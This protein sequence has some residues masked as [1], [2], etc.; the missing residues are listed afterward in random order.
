M[1]TVWLLMASS[2]PAQMPLTRDLVSLDPVSIQTHLT[3]DFLHTSPISPC[4]EC[5]GPSPS[6]H[7]SQ[8]LR[9]HNQSWRGRNNVNGQTNGQSGSRVRVSNPSMLAHLFLKLSPPGSGAVIGLD[10]LFPSRRW[11]EVCQAGY[12]NSHLTEY[13]GGKR[14]SCSEPRRGTER[15]G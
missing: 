7:T 11:E 13:R 14:L 9:I 8:T 5:A 6:D 10:T 2:I 12:R 4:T 1:E 15:S 3:P